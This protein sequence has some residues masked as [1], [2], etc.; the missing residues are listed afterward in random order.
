M[1]K[2]KNGD[3]KETQ[4]WGDHKRWGGRKPGDDGASSI[5]DKLR[6]KG[7]LPKPTMSEAGKEEKWNKLFEESLVQ[8]YGHLPGRYF[9]EHLFILASGKDSYPD[10][11]GCTV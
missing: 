4:P 7:S 10:H 5:I 2:I 9:F 11:A 6:G 3:S 1:D 8:H